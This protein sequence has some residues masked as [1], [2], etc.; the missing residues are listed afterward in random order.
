MASQ[1][2]TRD[3]RLD[4]AGLLEVCGHDRAFVAEIIG[5]FQEVCREVLPQLRAA[6]ARGDAAELVRHAHRLKGSAG[7]LRARA[8]QQVLET[9]E[10]EARRGVLT[11]L[12]D[13]L[14]QLDVET[15]AVQ[16]ILDEL[17]SEPAT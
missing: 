17:Q 16:P 14:Q 10:Q 7:N 9:L 3:G 5:V 2:A 13:R 8:L 12:A 15:A 4:R 1:D 6:A 11:N